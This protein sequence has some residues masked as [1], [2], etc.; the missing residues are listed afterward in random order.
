MKMENIIRSDHDVV[1]KKI[2][3]KDGENV[4]V[5]QVVIDFKD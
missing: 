3:F 1:I 2:Y 4:G 5:G